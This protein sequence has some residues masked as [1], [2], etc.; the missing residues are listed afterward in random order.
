MNTRFVVRRSLKIVDVAR[1]NLQ[2]RHYSLERAMHLDELQ[3]RANI[4]PHS[5]LRMKYINHKYMV[6]YLYLICN[7]RVPNTRARS[8]FVIYLV[9]IRFDLS[10]G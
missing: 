5:G 6:H 3:Y 1:V 8:Y 2:E 9:V 4:W 7:A 10:M